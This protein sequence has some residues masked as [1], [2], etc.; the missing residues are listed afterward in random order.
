[1]QHVALGDVILESLGTAALLISPAKSADTTPDNGLQAIV[2]T[3][4][5]HPARPF[6]RAVGHHYPWLPTGTPTICA[7]L[8]VVSIFVRQIELGRH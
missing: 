2:D 5:E 4:A 1:M 6:L 7:G 8:A 3:G